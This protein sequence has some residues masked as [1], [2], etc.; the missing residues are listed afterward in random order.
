M[1]RRSAPSTAPGGLFD[2]LPDR[3]ATYLI[4][5]VYHGLLAEGA[6]FYFTNIARN[7]PYRSLIEHLGEWILIERSEDDIRALCR[8]ARVPEEAVR[9]RRDET[10]LAVLVEVESR[11]PDMTTTS[12]K[13]AISY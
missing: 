2:Y 7:N 10:G 12:L 13:Q 1:D 4:E 11:M 9:T 8:D 5:T 6:T 3:H